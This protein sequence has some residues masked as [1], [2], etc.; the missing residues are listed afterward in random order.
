MSE[1][2]QI[3]T[4]VLVSVMLGIMLIWLAIK[5]RKNKMPLKNK[6]EYHYMRDDN[7][8]EAK[9]GGKKGID[10]AV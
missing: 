4:L 5:M 3:V 7:L 8:F 1:T 6:D 9:L 10:V 2:I